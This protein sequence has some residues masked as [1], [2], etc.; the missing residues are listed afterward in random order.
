MSRRRMTAAAVVCLASWAFAVPHPVIGQSQRWG[1]E[2]VSMIDSLANERL[3]EGPVSGFTIGVKR[4]SE[5]LLVKGYGAADLEQGVQA[6]AETVYRIGSLTKQF[7]AAS[8]MRLVEQ[9]RIDLDESITTY[10]PDYRRQGQGVTV[11]HLLTHTSGIKSYTDLGDAFWL[12]AGLHDLSHAGMRAL[13]EDEPFDFAPGEEYRYNNSA[14]YLLGMII[15]E[16]S[17]RSYEDYLSENIFLPLG[18]SDSSYCHESRITPHRAQGYEQSEGALVNDGPISMNTPGAAGALCSTVLDLLS[19]TGAL[20]SGRVVTAES[21]DA[22]TT[23]AQLNDGS[24][25]AYGFGLGVGA[26]GGH[27]RIGHT[28]G[29]NGFSTVMAHYPD[30][31]LDIVILSNTSSPAPSQMERIIAGWALGDTNEG[32]RR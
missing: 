26:L 24:L 4:G 22:M 19:W 7:T 9:G 21:Y 27:V 1:G 3:A 29:I 16:A 32:E 25:T 10:L 12:E 23:P 14:Y 20:R 13:F 31:D 17:G 11:R 5:V 30:S 6:N 2:L 8:V 18:L 15:E 28:G